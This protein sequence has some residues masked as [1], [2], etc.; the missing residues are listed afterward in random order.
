MERAIEQQFKQ[1][2]EKLNEA[3]RGMQDVM[4]KLRVH[5]ERGAAKKRL[6]R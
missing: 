4:E 1:T 5:L 6:R 2:T 3:E